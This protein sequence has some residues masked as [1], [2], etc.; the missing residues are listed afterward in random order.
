ETSARRVAS[1]SARGLSRFTAWLAAVLGLLGRE[2]SE[3]PSVHWAI[4]ATIAMIIPLVI[5]AVLAGVYLQRDT[6]AQ[7]SAIKQQMMEE[8]A[9]AETVEARSTEAQLH[10]MQVLALACQAD[11]LRPDDPEVFRMRADALNPLDRIDGVS[12]MTAASFYRHDPGAN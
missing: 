8:L 11:E 5:G 7:V 12:R 6:V 9:A 1:S 4:P 3:E 10:Y 2:Q